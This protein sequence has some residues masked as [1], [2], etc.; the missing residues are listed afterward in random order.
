MFI[1]TLPPPKNTL[2]CQETSG[3]IFK[4]TYIVDKLSNGDR[5]VAITVYVP[6]NFVFTS[7][8]EIKVVEHETTVKAITKMV[9]VTECS[10]TQK[11]NPE[12]HKCVDICPAGQYLFGDKCYRIP[13]PPIYMCAKG[14]HWEIVHGMWRCVPYLPP[15]NCT[16]L[17]PCPIRPPIKPTCDST[18]YSGTSSIFHIV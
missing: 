18:F 5:I 16:P 6:A 3:Q 14:S 7:P 8:T 12:I 10:K 9:R 2:Q 11:W 13:P 15:P 1:S 4:C 17:I